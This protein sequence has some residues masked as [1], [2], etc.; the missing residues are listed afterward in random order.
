MNNKSAL[1]NENALDLLKKT[2]KSIQR[3]VTIKEKIFSR[4]DK[5]SSTDLYFMTYAA[6]LINL[7]RI[8]RYKQLYHVSMIEQ[9]DDRRI[10]RIQCTIGVQNMVH[11]YNR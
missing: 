9:I 3:F 10:R 11:I 6:G 4:T 5:I 7:K 1:N 2:V 8:D